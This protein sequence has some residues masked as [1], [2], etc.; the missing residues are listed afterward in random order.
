M[1]KRRSS[2]KGRGSEILFGAPAPV[3]IEPRGPDLAIVEEES[4]EPEPS[5]EESTSEPPSDDTDE[6]SISGFAPETTGG[7]P[8]PALFELEE[9]ELERALYEEAQDGEPGPGREEDLSVLEEELPP[10]PEME[11]AFLEEAMGAEEPPE[12]VTELPIP[13]MEEMME[14]E[15]LSEEFAIFE[16]PPPEISDIAAGVVPPRSIRPLGAIEDLGS[17]RTADVQEGAGEVEAYELPDLALTDEERSA[18]LTRL[19]DE[20][21]QELDEE[22]SRT[23]DQV[24]NK[25]GENEGLA[26]ECYNQL[27]KARDIVLRRDAARIA[28]AEYYVEQVRA[29]LK[30]ASE[31]EAGAKKYAWW[32]AGW[33]LFWFAAYITVLILLNYDWFRNAV[34][35]TVSEGSPID[36]NVFLPAMVWGGIG[37]VAAV[38]YSLFKHVGLRDFDSQYNLSY[39]G[40]PF[41]GVILGA[42]VYM[43]VHL[44]IM[45]LGILPAGLAE[46]AEG[47]QTPFLVPWIIYITAWACGFK[48]N[49]IFDLVD[50]LMKRIFSGGEDAEQEEQLE[51][52][53]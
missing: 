3:E 2:L 8:A 22:I 42:T 48:E 15:D 52:P 19:G 14:E 12:P 33:G 6:E 25:V 40:K 53:G 20:Q 29:L 32:I 18:I 5:V 34:A 16:P 45:V 41:L 23:Y 4:P 17:L 35:P 27:L 36:M 31:S 39:V 24:L 9:E 43:I 46:G 50:R 44:M 47:Y 30:R 1:A 13:T 11:T 38:F 28:Q 49:R 37:G 7:T 10:T 26:T 51:F 21:I